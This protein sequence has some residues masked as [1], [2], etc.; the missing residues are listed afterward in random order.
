MTLRCFQGS[1]LGPTLAV[2]LLGDWRFKRHA[3]RDTLLIQ[4]AC[5]ARDGSDG[6]R[7][8]TGSSLRCMMA[9]AVGIK[10]PP[11]IKGTRSVVVCVWRLNA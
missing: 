3:E 5:P 1:L 4:S 7:Y 6:C 11:W 8:V 2:S 10:A 9:A